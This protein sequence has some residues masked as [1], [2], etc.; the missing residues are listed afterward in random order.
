MESFDVS[1]A[2]CEV[3]GDGLKTL[4]RSGDYGL[5]KQNYLFRSQHDEGVEYCIVKEAVSR[6]RVIIFD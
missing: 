5:V 2:L 1:F 3:L 4:F 6:E